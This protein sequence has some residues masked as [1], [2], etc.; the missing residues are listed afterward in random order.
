V[1]RT[2]RVVKGMD[3]YYT[4][5]QVAEMLG[6]SEITVR[7]YCFCGR[8]KAT[9]FGNQFAITQEAVDE[10]KATKMKKVVAK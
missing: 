9:T 8:I 2:K 7:N 4:T 1:F 6:F 5:R 10:F 3:K